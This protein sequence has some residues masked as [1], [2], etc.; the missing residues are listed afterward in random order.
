MRRVAL[1]LPS[2]AT[3]PLILAKS[4]WSR[5]MPTLTPGSNWVPRWRIRMWPAL[6]CSPANSLTPS[7]FGLLSRPFRVEPTPFLCA[8]F[9]TNFHARQGEATTLRRD[10][11]DANAGELLAMAPVAML[12]LRRLVGEAVD[13]RS[14]D[15]SD[16]S[17]LDGRAF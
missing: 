1:L 3:K 6:T 2:K 12:V 5:P 8:M 15:L 10:G 17:R 4:V 9:Y 13:L 16:N 11:L 14:L 7:I